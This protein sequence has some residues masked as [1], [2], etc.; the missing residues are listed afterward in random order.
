M[1]LVDVGS[2]CE[3][4]KVMGSFL[5][6]ADAGCLAIDYQ[7][8]FSIHKTIRDLWYFSRKSVYD[9]KLLKCCWIPSLQ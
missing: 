1:L 3:D 6:D 8:L 2:S 5:C 4:H 7:Y 9:S